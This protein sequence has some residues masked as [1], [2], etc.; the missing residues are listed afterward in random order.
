MAETIRCFPG[1]VNPR[2]WQ[3]T[4][5]LLINDT[6]TVLCLLIYPF[7]CYKTLKELRVRP[8]N[9]AIQPPTVPTVRTNDE[10]APV[11]DPRLLTLQV[12]KNT[13]ETVHRGR[14]R[15]RIGQQCFTLSLLVLNVAVL[16][17]PTQVF[18]TMMTF[19]LSSFSSPMV[20]VVT[21]LYSLNSIVDPIMFFVSIKTFRVAVKNWFA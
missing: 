4:I 5:Q 17:L 1:S 18:H 16:Q 12:S 21:V 20:R 6:P 7:I 15:L 13:T 9:V 3:R 8:I 14:R 2:Y 19:G 11:A 10:P